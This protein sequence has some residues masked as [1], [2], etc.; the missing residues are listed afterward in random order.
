MDDLNVHVVQAIITTTR[1]FIK[2]HFG[3]NLNNIILIQ[4][5]SVSH[6]EG[7]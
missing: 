4:P 2:L 7:K 1:I 6:R 3:I 5:P